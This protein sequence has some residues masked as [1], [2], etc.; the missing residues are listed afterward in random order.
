MMH[1]LAAGAMVTETVVPTTVVR[2]AFDVAAWIEVVV[3]V[4]VVL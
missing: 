3:V 1:R 4:V 2:T